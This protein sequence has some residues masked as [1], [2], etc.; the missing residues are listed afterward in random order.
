MIGLP[1]SY[2]RYHKCRKLVNFITH[3][4]IKKEHR[5]KFMLICIIFDRCRKFLSRSARIPPRGEFFRK[6][7]SF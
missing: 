7:L 5:S 3:F 4:A 1:S 2:L 6:S